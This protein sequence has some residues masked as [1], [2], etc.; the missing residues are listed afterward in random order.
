MGFSQKKRRALREQKRIAFEQSKPIIINLPVE[1]LVIILSF[2]PDEDIP[3][4]A[5]TCTTFLGAFYCSK[6]K[7]VF[8][9][10]YLASSLSR[11]AKLPG[12]WSHSLITSLVI[13]RGEIDLLD[14]IRHCEELRNHSLS[15]SDLATALHEGHI[16]MAK[17]IEKRIRV[18]FCKVKDIDGNERLCRGWES[19]PSSSHMSLETIEYIFLG[20]KTLSL[21]FLENKGLHIPN[22]I[23]ELLE[24]LITT[25]SYDSIR[26]LL[27]NYGHQIFIYPSDYIAMAIKSMNYE[28]YLIV[29]LAFDIIGDLRTSVECENVAVIKHQLKVICDRNPVVLVTLYFSYINIKKYKIISLFL[30]SDDSE[31][32]ELLWRTGVVFNIKHYILECLIYN[33]PK[34]FKFLIDMFIDN[35]DTSDFQK[36]IYQF[37]TCSTPRDRVDKFMLMIDDV[38]ANRLVFKQKYEEMCS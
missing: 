26:W 32:M 37:K 14:K 5:L 25:T 1:L 27:Q 13:T 17:Y 30:N 6:R 19:Y 9:N 16:R 34:C 21:V 3:F 4:F 38:D 28:I 8:K 24:Y 10:Y 35:A 11:I 15:I 2:L 23:N 36:L 18:C 12:S 20:N 22:I 7:I 29:S 31:G 33:H